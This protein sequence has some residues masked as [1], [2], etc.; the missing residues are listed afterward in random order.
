MLN[1]VYANVK[2]VQRHAHVIAAGLSPYG[3]PP[4]GSR[5]APVQFLR[6]LLCLHGNRM[7]PERCPHPA[8]LDAIA[9]HPYSLNPTY[10]S[11]VPLD[12]RVADV[13][14]LRPVLVAARRRHRVLPRGPV[15]PIW[16]TE[17]DWSSNPPDSGGIP[18]NQQASYLEQ[19]FYQLWRQGVGHV[20]WF[21]IRDYPS[22]PFDTGGGV[23]FNSSTPK[24]S[25][26][27]FMFPFV[28]TPDN[29]HHVLILWGRS[30]RRGRVAI[31]S[32]TA[33]GWRTLT[34]L[35]T[36]A[37]G[38]F[39]AKRHL[40]RHLTLRAQIGPYTSLSWSTG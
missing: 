34:R 15:K 35:K 38:V 11:P 19:A 22:Y 39:Y 26:T 24:P 32:Q 16:E 10:S 14:R 28:A 23:Y 13:H 40:G 29:R 9:T 30:P 27:A 25:A 20:F 5:M 36:T 18:V 33:T 31:A 1:A 37:G 6:E 3:D 12:T 21:L 7:R 2:A 4:G 17:L 8:H